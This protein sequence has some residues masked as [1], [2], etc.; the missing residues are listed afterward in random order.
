MT[1]KLPDTAHRQLVS[2]LAWATLAYTVAVIL[3]GA[4][5]RITGSGAGCGQHW[6]TCQGEIAHLPRTVATGIELSHRLTSG[7]SFLVVVVLTITTFRR[8]PPNHLARK[9]AVAALAFMIAEVSVGAALVLLALVGHNDSVARALVMAIHLVN[10]F[11]LAGSLVLIARWSAGAG[12]GLMRM[13][14]AL[15]FVGIAALILFVSVSGAI[16]AL[17]D[18]V[19]PANAAEPVL[20]RLQGSYAATA[21]FLDRLRI[22][23]P[24]LAIVAGLVILALANRLV[25]DSPRGPYSRSVRLLMFAVVTQAAVGTLNIWLSAPAWIQ[26]VHLAFAL[27]LWTLCIVAWTLA[28]TRGDATT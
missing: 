6:P 26:L 18:T 17:G 11:L 24:A 27:L 16:T 19:R 22:L 7:L 12:A 13:Q 23:H 4:V 20:A 9:A 28:P 3:F 25:E 10:T 21:H 1:A 2:K 14:G 15:N 8:F 5:V